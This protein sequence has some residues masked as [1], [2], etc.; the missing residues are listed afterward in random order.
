MNPPTPIRIS[1]STV[2]LPFTSEMSRVSLCDASK[3]VNVVLNSEQQQQL[4]AIELC[5]PIVYNRD[6]YKVIPLAIDNGL[7]PV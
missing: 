7:A 1:F 2:R 5:T 4:R 6:L 3:S